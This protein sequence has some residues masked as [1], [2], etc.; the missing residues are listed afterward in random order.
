[1]NILFEGYNLAEYD[2]KTQNRAGIYTVAWNVFCGFIDS[3][4]YIG[5][6]C[7]DPRKLYKVQQLI[8]EKLTGK[9]IELIPQKCVFLDICSRFCKKMELKNLTDNRFIKNFMRILYM[10]CKVYVDLSCHV[11]RDIDKYDVYF[12]P[13]KLFPNIIKRNQNIFKTV[14]LHDVIPYKFPQYYPAM[15]T[16]RYWNQRLVRGIQYVD[17]F[18]ANS[19]CTKRDYLE[20]CKDLKEDKIL[21]TPLACDCRFRA[22]PQYKKQDTSEIFYVK[23]KYDIPQGKKYVFS[24]CNIDPRKNLVRV[25]RTFIKFVNKNNIEDLIFVIG[26][27]KWEIFCN[28]FEQELDEDLIHYIGYVDDE[29]LADLYNGALWFTYTSQYEGFGLPPLEAMSCGCPVITSN[30]SSLP[31]VVD[32]A[33]IQIDWDDDE[34][35]ISAYEKYYFDENYRI[36]MANKAIERSKMFSW[37]KTCGLILDKIEEQCGLNQA[38][39]EM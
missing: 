1:M 36:R 30:S 2:S 15:K 7:D 25:I 19:E 24:L 5:I 10:L 13:S 14:F 39:E 33:G 27:A 8:E 3:N 18:F 29:D 12:S 28:E 37:E 26:G 11:K 4:N 31:E 38:C 32:D 17:Y 20:L 22:K 9:Q 16:H 34:Q 23:D 21:V 6:Y 35:H